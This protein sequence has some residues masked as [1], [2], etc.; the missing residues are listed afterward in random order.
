V[1]K[2]F[3]VINQMETDGVIGRYAIG[4]AVGSI[5]WLEPITTKDVDVFVTLHGLRLWRRRSDTST[6]L[7]SCPHEVST[8]PSARGPVV[9]RV[10]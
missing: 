4:G 1:E 2:I 6:T 9:N 7:L 3:A 10:I 8:T 5:F